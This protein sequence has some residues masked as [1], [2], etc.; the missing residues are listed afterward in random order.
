MNK[1]PIQQASDI[2]ELMLQRRQKLDVMRASGDNPF[3]SKFDR[4]H[5]LSEIIE[6]FVSIEA[7]DQTGETVIVAGRI[8]A[9]RRHGK[10]GFMVLKDRTAGIQLFLSIGALG[11]EQYRA[12]LDYDIGDIVGVTGIVFK[13]RRGELSIDVRDFSLLT[14]SLRP[15]PEKWHGLKDVE[16]RHRQ[17][18]VD[19]I[20]NE[21]AR[22]TLLT[23]TRIIKAMRNWLDSRDFIEVETP[24][25]QA[26]PGGAMAKPFITHHQALDIDLYMRIAPELYL[27]R[28]IVGDMERVYELNRNFR[29][30]GISVRHNPEF[31]MLEVYQAYADYE[32]MMDLCEGLIKHVAEEALGALQFDY[33][34]K[35]VDLSGKWSRLT[36]IESIEQYGG[37]TVSFDMDIDDL[38]SVAKKHGIEVKSRYGKGKLIN[39][40]FEKL[41]ET[42]LWQPTFIID[43]PTEISPLAK[44]KQD[45]PDVTERFELIVIGLEVGTAFS[46]LTDPIDQRERFEAQVKLFEY[47]DEEAPKQVDED[48][49]RALEYG[50]PPTGGMGIGIDRL[51]MLLTDN[52]SIREVISFPHMRP[53]KD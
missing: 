53:E 28:L 27:K 44:K 19:L 51:V 13:T 32:D 47:G 31:T 34:D 17:R 30:E 8:M 20:I 25:L 36:M 49:V 43:Y 11:E 10:A 48:Y 38:R 23:R 9:I 40:L 24:M 5:T 22:K 2:N 39:E 3:K 41:V 26:I 6:R 1:E 50:M 18:Y 12:F 45:N 35:P 7:G 46:E 4:T 21:Q 16:T 37:E 15:L 42:K 33:Q 52:Y 29:N 14:K